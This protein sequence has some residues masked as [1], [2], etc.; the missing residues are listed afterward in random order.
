MLVPVQ[1]DSYA[2]LRVLLVL[3]DRGLPYSAGRLLCAMCVE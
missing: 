1:H 2:H 3:T